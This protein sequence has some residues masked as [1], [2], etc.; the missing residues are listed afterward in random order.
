ML[1]NFLMMLTHVNVRQIQT[2]LAKYEDTSCAV[3][4]GDSL[5]YFASVSVAISVG[6]CRLD[7]KTLLQF[8]RTITYGAE[9]ICS[10][11]G[12]KLSG[13]RT[14]LIVIQG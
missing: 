7:A 14:C 2:T 1:A 11:P 5:A 3:M 8:R 4:S 6:I 9:S 10:F 13:W 12:H